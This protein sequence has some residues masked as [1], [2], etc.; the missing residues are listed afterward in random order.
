MPSDRTI[1]PRLWQVA[2]AADPTPDPEL[3]ARFVRSRD[4]AAFAQLVERHGPMVLGV[5]RRLLADA[6]AAEDAFQAAF[7]ALARNANRVRNANAL[8]AWLYGAA[9]RVALKSRRT[10]ARARAAV[11]RSPNRSPADPLAEITGR[12]LV[13]AVD[14]ELARLPDPLRA[15]VVLCCLE[16]LSQEEAARRLGWTPGSVRGRL[17]RGRERLRARLA[18]RGITLAAGAGAVLIGDA[19]PAVPPRLFACTI[20]LLTTRAVEPAVARLAA[21]AIPSGTFAKLAGAAILALAAGV[22]VA[23]S[24][25]QTPTPLAD[26]KPPEP[27]AAKTGPPS[28]RFGDPL[29]AGAVARLGTI[30]QR[31]GR[32]LAVWFAPD[33][34]TVH[35]FGDGPAVRTW[36]AAT[37]A[38]LDAKAVPVD[39][40]AEIEANFPGTLLMS[41][42]RTQGN[43]VSADGRVFAARS[44]DLTRQCFFDLAA[45]R[46]IRDVTVKKNLAAHTARLSADGS[47]YAACEYMYGGGE[48]YAVRTYDVR[49]GTIRTLYRTPEHLKALYL[50]PDGKRLI[51]DRSTVVQGD[52]VAC[53]D[54]ATGERVWTRKH[55]FLAAGLSDDG[56]TFI[57]VTL[58][59]DMVQALDAATGE[60]AD[61]FRVPTNKD[62]QAWNFPIGIDSMKVGLHGALLTMTSDAERLV[63]DTAAGR[64]LAR[65]P[66]GY[67][68]MALAPDGKSLVTAGESLQRWNAAD[69]KPLWPD[70]RADGH[71]GQVRSVRFS[72]DGRK[73]VSAGCD[74]SV[75]VWDVATKAGRLLTRGPAHGSSPVFTPDGQLVVTRGVSA[76]GFQP[77]LDVRDANTGRVRLSLPA[78]D[79]AEGRRWGALPYEFDVAPDGKSVECVVLISGGD[80]D[81]LTVLARWDLASGKY[82]G[83]TVMLAERDSGTFPPDRRTVVT[84]SQALYDPELVDIPTA[85][86]KRL[87]NDAQKLIIERLPVVS[88]DG[89]LAAAPTRPGTARRGGP[90]SRISI[91]ET[92]TGRQVDGLPVAAG[93]VGFTPD[94]RGLLVADMTGVGIWDLATRKRIVWHTAHAAVR[95]DFSNSF[96][97]CWDVTRDGRTVATG[98][99]DGTILLWDISDATRRP[100][101]PDLSAADLDRH[102]Q[103]LAGEDATAAY[104]AVRELAARPEQA[105]PLLRDRLKPVEGNDAVRALIAKLDAPAFSDREAAAKELSRLGDAAVPDLKQAL[106]GSPSAEQKERIER[107]LS[108]ADA[109]FPESGDRLRAVRAVGVLEWIGTS[110]ARALL[111]ELAAGVDRARLTREAK[112]AAERLRA[113]A[114]R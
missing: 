77:G 104:T 73:L 101:A 107:L 55:G 102:W 24:T 58:G 6:H 8:A 94:S 111:R 30:R 17:E 26:P 42:S 79:A 61:T 11:R 23:L 51:A 46:P 54:V 89:R 37:G 70:N 74:A 2:R 86:R 7:L 76:D 83:R 106:A 47:V 62:F 63:W 108:A 48:D 31:H 33:S 9:Y 75:R 95:S 5:C 19:A 40:R 18:R 113:L 105:V 84:V 45:G 56:R 15:A 25:T 88:P 13:S 98:H 93:L 80:P 36:D 39:Y 110:E 34:K 91:W 16:G 49:A 3:L 50:T 43:A 38:L 65:L 100:A 67:G 68:P 112:A 97:S 92:A 53:W 57:G 64:L 35:A 32:A 28:D 103:A 52:G 60:R 27:A 85:A 81:T 72:A 22:V 99:P 69:G 109:R 10:T 29:P 82:L 96:V 4:G 71:S 1:A 78:I 90:D 44:E 12:E 66:G 87:Q 21:A 114:R 41:Y 20:E 59:E 14:D